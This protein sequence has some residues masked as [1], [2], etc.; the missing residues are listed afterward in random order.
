MGW[1]AVCDCGVSW[2]RRYKT[3]SILNSI[4]HEIYPAHNVKLFGILAFISM[5]N[6]TSESLKERGN[7]YFSAFIFSEKLKFYAQLS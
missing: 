3:F 4:E 1:Y 5:I 2:P 7:L 6:A